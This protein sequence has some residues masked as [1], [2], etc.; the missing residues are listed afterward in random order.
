MSCACAN[1]ENERRSE[2]RPTFVNVTS[3]R[4]VSAVA[5][6]VLTSSA[7]GISNQ[8]IPVSSP[9]SQIQPQRQPPV[10]P[11]NFVSV[12]T[13][14]GLLAQEKYEYKV[15]IFNAKKKSKF[16]V[17]QLHR[18][19]GKFMS[20]NEIKEALSDKDGEE[21]PD[22]NCYYSLGYFEGRYQKKRWLANGEDLSL[23]YQKFKPGSEIF[24]W[25]DGREEDAQTAVT[26][27]SSQEGNTNKRQAREEEIDKIVKELKEKHDDYSSTSF[28]GT[29]DC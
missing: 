26:K 10:S 12:R 5:I 11:Q 21:I 18:C 15:K 19:D 4:G 16:V 13:Q 7:T 20:V 28:V 9:V 14:A 17:R 23:M 2:L 3:S 22:I 27:H 1:M 24:L 8:A 6:Q 29:Y 25:C